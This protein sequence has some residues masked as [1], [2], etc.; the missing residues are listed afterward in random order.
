MSQKQPQVRI[1]FDGHDITELLELA[2]FLSASEGEL[3]FE[4]TSTKPTKTTT[5]KSKPRPARAGVIPQLT[6]LQP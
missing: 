3:T 1:L 2:N 6:P 5:K 4:V